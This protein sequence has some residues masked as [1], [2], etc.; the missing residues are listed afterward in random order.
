MYFCQEFRA[1][2]KEE[3]R[4]LQKKCH[5]CITCLSKCGQGHVCPI[6]P[7]KGC[8]ASH[9]ILLCTKE[10]GEEEKVFLS[11]LDGSSSNESSSEEDLE[12]YKSNNTEGAYI[13]KITKETTSTPKGKP[14]SGG[15]SQTK[16]E[17]K[18]GNKNSDNS[19]DHSVKLGKV[20]DFLKNLVEVRSSP[21]TLLTET[22]NANFVN[23][24]FPE[25]A[26][27]LQC[28]LLNKDPDGL[29]DGNQENGISTDE[30]SDGIP[31]GDSPRGCSTDEND[32]TDIS[33]D[34]RSEEPESLGWDEAFEGPHSHSSMSG[35]TSGGESPDELNTTI[36]SL[37]STNIS[38]VA[39]VCG[40]PAPLEKDTL[41]SFHT[42]TGS[43][44]FKTGQ[45][46]TP[47]IKPKQMPGE[48]KCPPGTD[49]HTTKNAQ[50]QDDI[51]GLVS[52]SGSDLS[53]SSSDESDAGFDGG[54]DAE[55]DSRSFLMTS[56]SNLRRRE[57]LGIKP[58]FMKK[59]HSK[60][61]QSEDLQDI[62]EPMLPLEKLQG[63]LKKELSK[64]GRGIKENNPKKS[65]FS[66][67]KWGDSTRWEEILQEGKEGAGFVDSVRIIHEPHLLNKLVFEDMGKGFSKL[68]V[69]PANGG[70]YLVSQYPRLLR[71]IG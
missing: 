52:S 8:G 33:D 64:D 21:K 7:C 53:S 26:C 24:F 63:L 27:F 62:Q 46:Q 40:I 17:T 66:A 55:C 45:P 32:G 9:N 67:R 59:K 25:R 14:Q 19:L 4:L 51:P 3:R 41:P 71:L 68:T 44:D 35:T 16:D 37:S 42:T 18:G 48:T 58:R 5:L 54:L 70:N 65:I 12:G 28:G 61:H 10:P 56:V 69:G 13:A 57:Q 20:K 34:E 2:S 36:T 43:E 38:P 49:T 15:G 31:Y 23:D 30:D 6:G 11:R 22:E 1:K 39:S 60:P 29:R 50:L 47:P